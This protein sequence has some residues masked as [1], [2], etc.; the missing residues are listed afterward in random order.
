MPD[1]SVG[2]YANEVQVDYSIL[3]CGIHRYFCN[4]PGRQGAIL[5]KHV[6]SFVSATGQLKQFTQKN[7]NFSENHIRER[8]N[9]W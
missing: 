1:A 7:N 2:T 4:N 3:L 6:C 9:S 8:L 5:R